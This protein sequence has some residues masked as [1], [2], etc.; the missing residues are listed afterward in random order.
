LIKSQEHR[1]ELREG[2][3]AKLKTILRFTRHVYLSLVPEMVLDTVYTVLIWLVRMLE[4]SPQFRTVPSS[5]IFCDGG[6][7]LFGVFSHMCYEALDM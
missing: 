3:L 2:F 6:K 7:V 5:S 4:K 1:V